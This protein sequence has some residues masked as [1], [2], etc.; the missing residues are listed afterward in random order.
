MNEP[1]NYPTDALIRSVV[2][3]GKLEPPANLHQAHHVMDT[4]TSMLEQAVEYVDAFV[5]EEMNRLQDGYLRTLLDE[6][7]DRYEK[8][9][10][11]SIRT[12]MF[13]ADS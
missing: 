3:G 9:L 10:G 4:L 13:G 6:E 8:E 2:S 12:T 11:Q 7:Y 5:E 1:R